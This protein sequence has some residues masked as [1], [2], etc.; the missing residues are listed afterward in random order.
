MVVGVGCRMLSAISCSLNGGQWWSARL[1][2]RVCEGGLSCQPKMLKIAL[3]LHELLNCDLY[4]L[5]YSTLLYS[6]AVP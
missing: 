2:R 3:K 6:T 1:R 4:D 5:L